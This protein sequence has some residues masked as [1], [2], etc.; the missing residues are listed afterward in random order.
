MKIKASNTKKK[1]IT[2]LRKK[3][4]E[5]REKYKTQKKG[6]ETLK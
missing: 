2:N 1:E 3:I 5:I 6:V 4:K